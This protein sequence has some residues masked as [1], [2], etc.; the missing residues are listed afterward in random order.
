MQK[1]YSRLEF[2]DAVRQVMGSEFENIPSHN[3]AVRKQLINAMMKPVIVG[4]RFAIVAGGWAVYE[5]NRKK[6]LKTLNQ[7]L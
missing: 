7:I 4:D 3:K 1:R 6:A 5:Y 2:D